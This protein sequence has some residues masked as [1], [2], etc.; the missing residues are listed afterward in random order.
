MRIMNSIFRYE[1][2][3]LI[4]NKFLAVPFILN[5]LCW[6]YVILSYEFQSVH[7]NERAAVFYDSYQWVL[8]L[9]L[10]FLGLFA[11]YMAGKDREN[12][13]EHLVIT[14]KVKNVE[15][16]LGKW[17]ITQ[18]FGLCI[19]LITLIIQGIWFSSGSITFGEWLKNIIYLFIQME[20]AFALLISLG[21]LFGILIRNMIAYVFIPVIL[22]GVFYLHFEIQGYSY[23]NPKLKLLTLYDSMFSNSPFNSIWGINAVFEGAI[24]H[25]VIVFLLGIVIVLVTLILY[26]PAR[27][28]RR[29]KKKI[30][31]IL[32]VISIPAVLLSGFR[33]IQYYVALEQYIQAGE[34]YLEDDAENSFYDSRQDQIKYDFSMERTNLNIQFPSENQID[35]ISSLM[36]KYN[37]DKPV[38]DV[39]LTL[40]HDLKV[41]ECYSESGVTCSREKDALVVHFN[42]MIEPNEEIHLMLNYSGNMKQYHNDAF[43]QH[44][45]IEANRI[46]LPKEA[47]WYPL[48]GKRHLAKSREHNN[49]YAQFEL[50][51]GRIVEDHPTEFI[52]EIT[53]KE[54]RIPIALTIPRVESGLYKGTSKYG[55]SLIGGNFEKVMVDHT[56]VVGHPEVLEGARETVRKYQK[57][58]KIAEEWLEVPMTPNV[59]YILDP[60]HSSLTENTP[61]QE[62]IVWDVNDLDQNDSIIPYK[63]VVDLTKG[64]AILGEYDDLFL[65]QKAMEWSLLNDMENETG[66]NKFKDWIVSHT[67]LEQ[68]NLIDILNRYNEKGVKE[69]KQVVKFLFTQYSQ[70]EE[71]KDFNMSAELQRYEGEK[72][73]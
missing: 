24:I 61:S 73:K 38:Q 25:Q 5:I 65:L 28:K 18:S 41:K 51:N 36:I 1:T 19:T 30:V 6:G 39:Y 27:S 4:R 57:G 33:Y 21:F 11:V 34:Y 50:R 68:T 58:W 67:G 62:F 37:G 42:N 17:L 54:D 35:V 53:N 52:V 10:L 48:I 2:L 63:I 45:F 26:N 47:G 22:A 32:M 55:L 16:I 40:H 72:S 69:F 3:L 44:S 59:I 12:N 20:G 66:F 46:Y 8:L 14:Y 13:F 49:R 23:I 29:D 64:E 9:N 15:W 31:V 70:L 71:E 56:R 60:V 43:V 7:Y